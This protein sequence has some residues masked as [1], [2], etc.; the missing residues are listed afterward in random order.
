MSA[1]KAAG[2]NAFTRFYHRFFGKLAAGLES[3]YGAGP[4][5]PEE[6][7]H[8]AFL[9]LSER[10]NL[11]EI[12][13]MEGFVWVTAHNQMRS[14]LRALRVRESYAETTILEAQCDTFDP[15]RVLGGKQE[16]AI[17]EETLRTM[18]ER[19]RGIFIANRIDGLTPEKAGALFGVSRTAAMRHIANASAAIAEALSRSDNPDGSERE[20]L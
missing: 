17:V 13:D 3:T 14:E 12:R 16:V 15:E 7:A 10:G 1:P 18:S 5:D 2:E 9:K 11:S 6:V 20:G 19:R 8:Q 4:P